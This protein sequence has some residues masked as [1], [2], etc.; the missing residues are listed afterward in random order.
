MLKKN[1]LGFIGEDSYSLANDPQNSTLF[2]TGN[3]YYGVRGSLEE[4][5]AVFIQGT[6]LRGVFDEIIEIPLTFVDNEYMKKYY[7]DEQKLKEFEYE[8][9]CIN[10]ADILHLRI[11]IGNKIFYPWEGKIISWE[12]YIDTTDGSLV[13][14]VCWD[15]GMGNQTLIKF[16]RFA[17]FSDNHLYLVTA[18]ITKLN[19]DLPVIVQ[20]GIDTFVKTNGQKKSVIEKVTQSITETE[21]IYRKMPKYK[22]QVAIKYQTEFRGFDEHTKILQYQDG[23]YYDEII[24]NAKEMSVIKKVY[25]YA[26]IDFSENQRNRFVSKMSRLFDKVK[27][28]S[29]EDLYLKHL[30]AYKKAFKKIDIKIKGDCELDAYL[31]Y[32]NYQTLIGFDRFDCVHSLSAKNLTAEKYNQFVWWDCEIYQ[33]PIFLATFPKETK[34]LLMYRYNRLKASKENAKKLGEKGAKYAFCSSVKGDE[35]VW[36]YARHPFLQIHINSDIAYSVINYYHH[37]LDEDFLCKYG[38]EM[39]FEIM[40]YFANRLEKENNMYHLKNV[41]G[42]DE[43]HPYVEDNAYTNYTIKYIFVKTLEYYFQLQAKVDIEI[44]SEEKSLFRDIAQKIYL[45]LTENRMIPQF[46]GYF[47]LSDTLEVVGNGAGT[48]F[49]MKQAGLYHKSQIIKQPDVLVLYSYLNLEM[50]GDYYQ[51]FLYYEKM[52]ESS[53]S[54]TYPVHAICAIDNND[55]DKFYDYLEKSIKIDIVDLH[56]CAHQGVHAAS[57][58]GGWYGIYRGLFGFE[59]WI[60]KLIINPHFITKFTLVKLNFVYQGV[61][62]TATLDNEK[63]E[64]RLKSSKNHK[65]ILLALKNSNKT[66]RHIDKTTIKLGDLK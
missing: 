57:M 15:D 9:S 34:S 19:H 36:S 22:H 7:F 40:R 41:T 66:W 31:R 13:R 4:F 60:D 45:P 5:G 33:Q 18:T 20:T 21:I 43:H 1:T 42:T 32:A 30:K 17:S 35:Q 14:N 50:P 38:F 44:S 46:K 62:I 27:V 25:T 2:G 58:A 56:K 8:D 3:G 49:Q 26:N 23:I 51:N 53:S 24:S 59:A 37:T 11:K 10:I 28:L 6:Y 63:N 65:P 16:R 47:E 55:E 52:C 39:N 64:L 12:R 54:L 29:Y 48:S 61:N